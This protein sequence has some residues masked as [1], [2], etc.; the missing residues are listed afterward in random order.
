MNKLARTI[1]ES[2][3]FE[4]KTLTVSDLEKIEQTPKEKCPVFITVSDGDTI[5]ASAGR[6]YP[7]HDTIGEELIENT[8][9]IALD[10]RFQ[11]YLDNPEKVRKIHYRIDIFHDE[12]RRLLHHP[13]ELVSASEGMILLCQKQE[14]IG[15]IL[16]H[17][18]T[19]SLSGEEIY[20]NLIRKIDLDTTHLGKWD[21]ILYGVKT[22]V[23]EDEKVA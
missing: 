18:L 6:I 3:L 23:F 16:P 5:V 8:T 22:E 13:D 9:L 17:M 7:K 4:K 10:P 20:H 1:L 15:I 14:K 19:S 11:P 12:D 21:V 2:F